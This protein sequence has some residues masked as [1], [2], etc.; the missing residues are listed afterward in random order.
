MT[1]M[2][3]GRK[4]FVVT[5]RVESTDENRTKNLEQLHLNQ[6]MRREDLT[7]RTRWEIEQVLSRSR[8]F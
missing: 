1:I 8:S 3:L 4:R 2:Q 6:R 5:F 7:R